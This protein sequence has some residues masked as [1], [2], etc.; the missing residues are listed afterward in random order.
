MFHVEHTRYDLFPDFSLGQHA[1]GEV[2]K[3]LSSCPLLFVQM[4]TIS[5]E[6]DCQRRAGEGIG[7]GQQTVTHSSCARFF[8]GSKTSRK[9]EEKSE[10]WYLCIRCTRT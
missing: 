5:L 3:D 1:A 6:A 2:S 4:C 10:A 7:R 8:R 9:E